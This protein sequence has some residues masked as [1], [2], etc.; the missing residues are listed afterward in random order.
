MLAI[1]VEKRNGSSESFSRDKVFNSMLGATAAPD[2]VEKIT[3]EIESW[4]RE[5][6]GGVVKSSEIRNKVLEL[7]REANP[8]AANMYEK[9]DKSR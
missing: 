2:E 7:L 8:Y 3:K 6:P 1:T 9:Y 5:V 4:A